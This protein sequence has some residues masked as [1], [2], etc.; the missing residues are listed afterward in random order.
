M[1]KLSVLASLAALALPLALAVTPSKS[2]EPVKIGFL[3]AFSGP[4]AASGVDM[5]DAFMLV[6]ERNGGKLGEVPVQV[7]KEDDQGKPEVANQVVDKLV[8]KD[9]VPIITGVSLSNVMVAIYNRVVD[10][11]VFLIG[12]NVSPSQMA[13]EQ[14]NPYYFQVAG[15]NDQRAEAVGRYAAQ[16]G[17]KSVYAM[18]PNYQ[19]GKDFLAGFKREY[20]NELMGEVYTPLSQLDFQAELLQLSADLPDAVF[21]F[22]PGALG[23]QFVRQWRQSGLADKIPLLTA[24]TID[25][26]NLPALQEA[27]EGIAHASLWGPDFDNPD[28]KRFVEEFTAKYG[29]EPSEYAATAYDSA[30][31]LDA[32][33]KNIAGDLSDHARFMEAL[34]TAEFGSVRGKFKFNDNQLPVQDFYIFEIAKKSDGAYSYKTVEKVMVDAKDAYHTLCKMP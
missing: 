15:Q 21:A 1:K 25:G 8:N 26:I 12:S 11:K 19:G 10:G 9:R 32:A 7:F 30:L 28:S 27:A 23:V 4:V 5:Y 24:S 17:Y 31:L 34:K 2:Q 29:R 13:G 22:Y 3:A 14:C 16:R 33:L 20:K 18:A 6:V